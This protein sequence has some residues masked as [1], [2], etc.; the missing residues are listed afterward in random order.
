[1]TNVKN[2][3]NAHC[4]D[5]STDMYFSEVKA[6]P[7]LNYE[8]EQALSKRI[9]SGDT[10]ARQEL[11]QGNLRL[12]ITIAKQ[13]RNSGVHFIDLVQEGNMGLM[14]AAQ[15]YDFTHEVRFS[16]YAAWWIKQAITR[17][18][19]NKQRSIRL[20]HRKEEALRRIRRSFNQLSQDLMRKPSVDE[21]AKD[22]GMPAR[23]VVTIMGI[24][25]GLISFDADLGEDAG[26]MHDMVQDTTYSPEEILERKM[27]QDDVNGLLRQLEDRER[28]V[29]TYRF[30]L[31]GCEKLTLKN[32]SEKMGVSPETVRQIEMRAIRKMRTLSHNQGMD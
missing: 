6:Y 5:E 25:S 13:Y 16:T 27:L 21:I 3:C 31:G 19:D 8:Q 18:I 9:M 22:I 14:H 23:E 1:M 15:K 24:G 26:T 2:T 17:A 30:A 10:D 32:I 11:V 4:F 29:L 7:L 12:V 20:P 28:D